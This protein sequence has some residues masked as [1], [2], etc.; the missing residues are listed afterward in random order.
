MKRAII[1]AAGAALALAGCK[2]GEADDATAVPSEAAATAQAEPAGE[3]AGEGAAAG[4]AAAFTPGEAPSKE[5]MVGKWAEKDQCDLAIDFKA[6][7]TMIGPFEKWNLADGELEMV[8]NPQ[9]IKL[10]VVDR[11]TM[12]SRNGDDAPRTLV[13]CA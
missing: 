8:G 1:I 12:E 4:T 9:K 5:F 2:Q 13:R 7:G 10:K 11:D 6:D 3:P